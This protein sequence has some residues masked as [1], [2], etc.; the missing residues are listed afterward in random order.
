MNIR[1]YAT[2]SQGCALLFALLLGLALYAPTHVSHAQSV[3]GSDHKPS[4]LTPEK[5]AE[6]KWLQHAAQQPAALHATAQDQVVFQDIN[7]IAVY[8]LN[9]VL[10]RPPSTFDLT[11]TSLLITPSGNG[12]TLRN[13]GLAFSNDLGT[14]LNFA[15]APAVNPK[16]SAELG[17]DAYLSQALGFTFPFYGAG[18]ANVCIASNGN[19][20]FRATGQAAS[21]I[22]DAS[23][24]ASTESLV[25]LRSGPPRIAPYWD[26][27][28]ARATATTGESGIYLQRTSDRVTIT[29]NNIR[30][31]VGTESRTPGVHRFQVVLFADGRIQMSYPQVQLTTNALVGITPGSSINTPTL[32]NL[33]AAPTNVFSRALAE[34][35][36]LNQ[37][38]DELAVVKTFYATHPNRDSY[39]FI[40]VM[41]DFDFDIA[42]SQTS[43]LPIR[44]EI[45]GIGLPQFNHDPN[46]SLG[47]Q[48]LQGVVSLSNIRSQY[49]ELPTTRF[50]GGYHTLGLMLQQTGQRWLA[51]TRY[52]G[53][54]AKLLLGR[55][56]GFW[57]TFMHTESVMSHPAALRSSVMEGNLWQDFGDGRFASTSLP[58][59]FSLLDQYLIGLRVPAQVPDTFVITNPTAPAGVD[60]A[61]GVRPDLLV[62]GTRQNININQLIQANGARLPDKANAPRN[63]RA[64]FILVTRDPAQA[65][66]TITKITRTRL[67]FESYFTQATDYL[68]SII[69]G[70]SE[71]NAS[72][73]LAS[74][75]AASYQKC[76]APGAISAVF[77]VGLAT[78]TVAARTVPLPTTLADVSVFIDGTPAP[79]YFVSPTQINFQVPRNIVYRT[80]SP[81]HA[82]ATALIE[83]YLNGKLNRVGPL[84]I[85]AA[86]PAVFTFNATG[87]GAAAAIDALRNSYA[88]FDARQA[89]GSPNILAVFGSGLG[90]DATDVD[91][92]VAS[93]MTA[94]FNGTP[95]NVL[96]AGRAPGFVG[97]NQ[98]NIQLPA[99]LSAGTYTL[100]IARNGIPSGPVTVTVR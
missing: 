4:D 7:D 30:D 75:S 23:T 26:D 71:Q 1:V 11:G 100:V 34:F 80:A 99:H 68:A 19:L 24:T 79:L 86:T 21:P 95:G 48:R 72:L 39:D 56:E 98:F 76:L 81:G 50:F 93:G 9:N 28:D 90:V 97:L 3:A 20:T 42:G 17:D 40:Y 55:D 14:K 58:D 36:S 44:N 15:A 53:G 8:Q 64:A 65:S 59:G 25:E 74:V 5:Q 33:S 51:G 70:L 78:T 29:W 89:N 32:V 16:P 57:N 96:Y 43:Y 38:I 92:N 10:S 61:Y 13:T 18:Y 67:A 45:S 31:F 85:A 54:D 49:P 27:L 35:F 87:T 60:R 73:T 6:E 77:G 2:R 94:T 83:V 41:T 37:G 46:N 52:T 66:A 47:T 63:F 62:T 84:Q 88:P 69:T 22:F 12:Y 91:G 82:S